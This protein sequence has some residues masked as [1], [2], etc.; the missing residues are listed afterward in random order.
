MF[1]SSLAQ[2]KPISARVIVTFIPTQVAPILAQHH[3]YRVCHRTVL[4]Y[5]LLPM[6]AV[7]HLTADMVRLYT[8][9]LIQY[10]VSIDMYTFYL[11][12]PTAMDR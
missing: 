4:I 6:P 9:K 12:L 7:L 3:Q 2:L 8:G 1:S 11:V 5:V 10:D